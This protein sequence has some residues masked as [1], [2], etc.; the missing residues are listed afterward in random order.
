MLY[1]RKEHYSAKILEHYDSDLR[2]K[3]G[4]ISM[5]DEHATKNF[6]PTNS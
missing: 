3:G 4:R 1:S 6:L 2:L 5:N